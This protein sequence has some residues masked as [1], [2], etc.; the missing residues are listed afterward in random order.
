MIIV[1][2]YRKEKKN[3][4]FERESQELSGLCLT[5]GLKP[6]RIEKVYLNKINPAFYIG[7]GKAEE[8]K[9]IIDLYLENRTQGFGDE[10]KRRIMIGTYVLSSGY[11]EAYYLQA[12]KI[13]RLIA[14]E[15]IA[16]FKPSGVFNA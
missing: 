1:Y 8:I 4:D 6:V 13:R 11:Y 15:F 16:A 7:S 10:V 3:S 2:I 5:C 9:K 14:E 12:Q